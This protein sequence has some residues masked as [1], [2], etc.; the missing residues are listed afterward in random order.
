[1]DNKKDNYMAQMVRVE[2]SIT[3]MELRLVSIIKDRHFGQGGDKMFANYNPFQLE[4]T[5]VPIVTLF[6]R[7]SM[8]LGIYES[9]RKNG[10]KRFGPQLSEK[11]MARISLVRDRIKKS[12]ELFVDRF[13]KDILRSFYLA[14]LTE[15]HTDTKVDDLETLLVRYFGSAYP[16]I[17]S[18][19]GMEKILSLLSYIGK[20]TQREHE[21]DELVD[22]VKA[23]PLQMPVPA[24]KKKDVDAMSKVLASTENKILGLQNTLDNIIKERQLNRPYSEIFRTWTYLQFE[25][26]AVHVQ[27]NFSRA[28]LLLS[29]WEAELKY[30]ALQ[31]G[32][33]SMPRKIKDRYATV[34]ED[35]TRMRTKYVD[36]IGTNVLRG[37]MATLQ[38]KA[39]NPQQTI[40][41]L[42]NILI[43]Y[44]GVGMSDHGDYESPAFRELSELLSTIGRL[45]GKEAQAQK[46]LS[47]VVKT[48]QLEPPKPLQ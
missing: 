4:D 5:A 36:E 24:P 7:H 23:L 12:R 31:H 18:S 15:S 47:C 32:I 28:S 29:Y 48:S 11:D 14:I 22:A 13:G 17:Q 33:T 25:S 3:T 38:V 16:A 9:F 35:I 2:H 44:F 27:N 26:L 19:P 39:G 41:L 34:L 20:V 46:L 43:A 30:A 45:T 40:T 42:D 37:L 10:L 8:L 21:A 1:M 6:I